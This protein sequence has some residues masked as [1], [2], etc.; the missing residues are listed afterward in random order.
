MGL[1]LG[2]TI[3][4]NILGEEI[5]AKIANLREVNY[6]SL[7]MNFALIFSPGVIEH[8]PASGILTLH[9]DGK[10]NEAVLVHEM[11]K[12][13]PNISAIRI[14]ESLAQLEEI[15]GHIATAIRIT[16]IFTFISGFMVLSS[17]L[18]TALDKRAFDTV[19]FKVLG[20]RK[21]DIL[22][23]FLMEWFIIACITGLLSCVFGMIGSG[24]IL[25]RLS[26]V[27]FHPLPGVI[28]K[29]ML[30]TLTLI[31]CT[32]LLLYSRAFSLKANVILRNE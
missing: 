1:H 18:A 32:G 9:V 25:Q 19:I 23:V 29:A 10:E 3:T 12:K 6:L 4:L 27:E 30:L 2:D 8:F 11:T 14:R 17:A 31:A 28:A 22:A 5:D 7:R 15:V 26:W 16:A 20:A 13:F 24:L 21:R